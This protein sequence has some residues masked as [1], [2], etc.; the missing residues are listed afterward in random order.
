MAEIWANGLLNERRSPESRYRMAVEGIQFSWRWDGGRIS[1]NWGIIWEMSQGATT[2]SEVRRQRPGSD[3]AK[4]KHHA[5]FA[6]FQGQGRPARHRAPGRHHRDS[7][8]D[9][10]A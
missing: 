1:L 2:A 3:Q 7:G 9:P 4:G 8:G 10:E 5:G 6:D